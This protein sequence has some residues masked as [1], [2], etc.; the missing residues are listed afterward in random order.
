MK[1]VPNWKEV[2]L[3]SY[4]F[5]INLWSAIL[6]AVESGASYYAEGRWGRGLVVTAICGAAAVARLVKQVTV[7]GEEPKEIVPLGI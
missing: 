2:T 1:L 4:S 5:H 7:S 3:Y 6:G